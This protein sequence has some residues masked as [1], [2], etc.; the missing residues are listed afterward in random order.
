MKFITNFTKTI[1]IISIISAS[2]CLNLLRRKSKTKNPLEL[3]LAADV[4]AAIPKI[5]AMADQQVAAARK[6][7]TTPGPEAAHILKTAALLLKTNWQNNNIKE[8]EK[9]DSN[10]NRSING[11]IWAGRATGTDEEN[12]R[13]QTTRLAKVAND[14]SPAPMDRAGV[15]AV[16]G[17]IGTAVFDCDKSKEASDPKQKG[18]CNIAR[19]FA[20]VFSLNLEEF[21]AM[22][23]T[24][25]SKRGGSIIA[26]RK[27]DGPNGKERDNAPDAQ[28]GGIKLDARS[29][30]LTQGTDA[31]GFSAK[32]P[33]QMIPKKYLTTCEEPWAGHYSGSIV[34][35]LFMLDMFT[36]ADQ[37]IGRDDPLKSFVETGGLLNNKYRRCKAALAA[38]FLISIGYHS[39]IEV[40]PTIWMYLGHAKPKIFTNDSAAGDCDTKSTSDI[41]GLMSECSA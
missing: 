25:K 17:D 13:M 41:V 28:T 14:N 32:W 18:Y 31:S 23:N 12:T 40:K 26:P 2:M 33:W 16:L 19:S 29:G 39:A 8:N 24:A 22:G 21:L 5:K 30:L 10:F 1:L 38:S 36:K 7:L 27:K 37:A 4:Q 9:N 6:L 15:L 20:G 3:T 35:V 34:E 11:G